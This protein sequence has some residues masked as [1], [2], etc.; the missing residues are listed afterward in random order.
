MTKV[1]IPDKIKNRVYKLTNY[2]IFRILRPC[3][4]SQKGRKWHIPP[5]RQSVITEL[6]SSLNMLNWHEHE[7]CPAHNISSQG[8]HVNQ[9]MW[10]WWKVIRAFFFFFYQD[11]D[12]NFWW[13][14]E[15]KRFLLTVEKK[16][17]YV[18][19]QFVPVP[20]IF[21]HVFVYTCIYP[22]HL[23]FMIDFFVLCNK[24]VDTTYLFH[25]WLLNT[26]I[27]DVIL[28]MEEYIT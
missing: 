14:L 19:Y 27:T 6:P 8:S 1:K 21:I 12:Q 7:T 24:N 10:L 28:L 4:G 18:K 22:L 11:T 3:N 5:F 13:T 2:G 17:P 25:D 9:D 20:Y 26:S 23:S 16:C 15:R